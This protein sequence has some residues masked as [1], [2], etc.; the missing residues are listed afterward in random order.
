MRKRILGIDTGTNSIGWSIVDY[1]D[2]ASE[3]RYTL[4]DRGGNIFQEGVKIEK[5]IESSKASERTGYKHQRVG[6][7]RRKV[8]KISLL[9][10]L[11]KHQLCPPLSV[12]ELKQWRSLKKYPLNETFMAWQ[13]TD[14]STGDNPYYFR[15]LCLTEKLDLSSLKN[16]Y[17]VGR[18]I[19]HLNQ[20][21]GFLSNRKENTKESDGEVKQDIEALAQSMRDCGTEYLGEYFY[22]LYQNGEK[23]RTKYTSRKDYEKELLAICRKQGLS[24]ELTQKLRQIIITQRPL[25]SQKHTVGRCVYEPSKSRCPMSHPLYE[26][27]RMYAFINNIKMQGP[28]DNELRALTENEKQ[29]IIPL[30]LKNQGRHLSLRISRRNFQ[31]ARKTTAITRTR[32]SVRTVL[33]I[34]WIPWLAVAQLLPNCRK[35][36]M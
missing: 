35:P 12:E 17:I 27:Y 26:Q 2:E 6:Y 36:L 16:R 11:I 5:G 25:K 1:D 34:I 31:T 8:R 22:R 7:W 33:T 28:S 4:I 29:A 3:N 19:Y 32:Q 15:H 21:R 13:R 20:R 18:A 14:D 9:K 23:I 24:E 30:F 10:I